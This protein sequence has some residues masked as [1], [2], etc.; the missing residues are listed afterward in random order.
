M[1]KRSKTPKRSAR[2]RSVRRSMY[3]VFLITIS[4]VF[5]AATFAYSQIIREREAEQ[6]LFF[7]K[8]KRRTFVPGGLVPGMKRQ[9]KAKINDL[10]SREISQLKD[11]IVTLDKLLRNNGRIT[12]NQVEETILAEMAIRAN[13]QRNDLSVGTKQKL[14]S[15]LNRANGFAQRIFKDK[16]NYDQFFKDFKE[17][18]MN[19]YRGGTF[20]EK[21]KKMRNLKNIATFDD[22]LRSDIK[23]R[24]NRKEEKFFV[25][26]EIKENPNVEY[27]FDVPVIQNFDQVRFD[28]AAA[29]NYVFNP[30][31]I[32]RFSK[33]N[34][35]Q[36][37]VFDPPNI[38]RF[39]KVKFDGTTSMDVDSL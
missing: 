17:D 23:R 11:K 28:G 35:G 7:N 24:I 36:N 15:A 10:W 14:K 18:L 9:E 6:D 38:S 27:K 37:Y 13:L 25:P 4:G 20:V 3:N 34:F 29:P 19:M 30:P 21:N 31:N 32:S 2:K 16:R 22:Y 1:K 5:F 8:M 26:L 33:V 12:R 39:S